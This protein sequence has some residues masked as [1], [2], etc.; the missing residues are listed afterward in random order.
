MDKFLIIGS[1]DFCCPSDFKE[2]CVIAC[3]GGL[4][5]CAAHGIDPYR[6]IGDMDSVSPESLGHFKDRQMTV[7]P[8]K[9][10]KTDI[11]LGIELAF[12]LGAKDIVLTGVLSGTRLDHT[13]CNIQLLKKMRRQGHSRKG[14]K[15]HQRY[16]SF[17]GRYVRG[18]CRYG[19]LYLRNAAVRK[20]GGSY[21]DGV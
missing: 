1:G 19:A 2:R 9:K 3:D 16:L 4:D 6:I 18:Y 10:D 17:K 13:L 5:H 7:F 20:G 8:V 21:H 14:D 11:E 15:C 12:E